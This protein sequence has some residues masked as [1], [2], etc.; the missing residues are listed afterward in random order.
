MSLRP[1]A[2]E[3]AY[4]RIGRVSDH[5]KDDFNLTGRSCPVIIAFGD[6]GDR[7]RSLQRAI[8]PCRLAPRRHGQKCARRPNG[9]VGPKFSHGASRSPNRCRRTSA[10]PIH[11]CDSPPKTRSRR[12]ARRSLYWRSKAPTPHGA[13]ITAICRGTRPPQ[14]IEAPGGH[15]SLPADRSEPFSLLEMNRNER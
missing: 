6:D 14:V 13:S 7:H 8:R 15:R 10:F 4:A 2:G 11:P 5:C 12:D 3:G 1:V 9:S